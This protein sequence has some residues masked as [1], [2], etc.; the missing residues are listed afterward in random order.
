MPGT[1][2][3]RADHQPAP[4]YSFGAPTGYETL[5]SATTRRRCGSLGHYLLWTDQPKRG[6][7]RTTILGPVL[8]G[9][10]LAGPPSR[11]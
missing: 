3:N 10:V 5:S 8:A 7:H 11:A 2:T 1:A 6:A 4:R 9:P